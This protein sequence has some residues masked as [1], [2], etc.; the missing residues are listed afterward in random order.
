MNFLINENEF[1]EQD[2]IEYRTYCMWLITDMLR[3]ICFLN[4]GSKKRLNLLMKFLILSII[5]CTS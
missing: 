4:I 3:T 5:P 2:W 1:D